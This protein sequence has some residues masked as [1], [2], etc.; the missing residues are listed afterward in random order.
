M[1]GG[2]PSNPVDDIVGILQQQAEETL[3]HELTLARPAIWAAGDVVGAP[4]S[5]LTTGRRLGLDRFLVLVLG[6]IAAVV[7]QGL[8]GPRPP[9][10]AG[11]RLRDLSNAEAALA[12][13]GRADRRRRPPGDF[14]SQARF[15]ER[16]KKLEAQ[17]GA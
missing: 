17:K 2:R 15:L 10:Q 3:A 7:V 9:A 14:G 12:Q 5:R 6:N 11:P 16:K 1:G 13:L 8:H 4:L